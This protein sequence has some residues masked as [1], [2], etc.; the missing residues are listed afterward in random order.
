MKDQLH[1]QQVLSSVHLFLTYF[2]SRFW[3]SKCLSLLF[4]SEA[5]VV[6]PLAC[7]AANSLMAKT[8]RVFFQDLL[9]HKE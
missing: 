4:P 2:S 8:S 7:P 9:G 1:Q 6:V 5:A 3:S